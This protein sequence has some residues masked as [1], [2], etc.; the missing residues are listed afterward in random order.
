MF[1][2]IEDYVCFILLLNVDF[3]SQKEW[4]NI[5]E[6][7]NVK[8]WD[9]LKVYELIG[10]V[11]FYLFIVFLF[12]VKGKK[13]IFCIFF[14]FSFEQCIIIFIMIVYYFDQFDVV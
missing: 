5:L 4:G 12:C 6:K 7:F 13:V 8:F 3:E 11:V 9:E 1:M 14:Y 10:V 2:K